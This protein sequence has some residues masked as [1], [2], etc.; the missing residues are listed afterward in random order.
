MKVDSERSGRNRTDTFSLS[1][2]VCDCVC[3]PAVAPPDLTPLSILNR[4]DIPS[5]VITA[6]SARVCVTVGGGYVY[7]LVCV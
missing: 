2:R 7:L 5:A 3:G 6:V 4:P 1:A